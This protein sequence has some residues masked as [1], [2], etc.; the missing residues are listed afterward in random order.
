VFDGGTLYPNLF[1]ARRSQACFADYT[2]VG[3]L[4]IIR[5]SMRRTGLVCVPREATDDSSIVETWTTTEGA[6]RSISDSDTLKP[7]IGQ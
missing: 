3:D 2:V 7:V 1:V 4:D 5:E 6:R